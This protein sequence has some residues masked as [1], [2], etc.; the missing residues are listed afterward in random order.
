MDIAMPGKAFG[1]A[2]GIAL[3][4]VQALQPARAAALDERQTAL[5]RANC[6]QCHA[7]PGDRA[8][9]IGDEQ[10]WK[11]RLRQGEARMLVNVV[12][13]LRGMPPLGYCSACSEQ[14]LRAL[15]RF[16]AGQP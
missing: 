9:Q 7:R 12:Q 14:D 6:L 1:A 3:L 15:V 10:A 4:L 11:A 8:P 16:V 5:L 13:G 2:A